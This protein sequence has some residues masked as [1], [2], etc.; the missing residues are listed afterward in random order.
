MKANKIRVFYKDGKGN[1]IAF[2]DETQK[3][4]WYK[5]TTWRFVNISNLT[6]GWSRTYTPIAITFRQ[7]AQP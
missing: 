2:I 3:A 5:Y 4:R 1:S 7:E 6:H